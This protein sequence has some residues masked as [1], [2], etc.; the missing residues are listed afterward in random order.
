[1][2]CRWSLE[3]GGNF[4][5]SSNETPPLLFR[6]ICLHL[7]R[8]LGAGEEQS[9]KPKT[10][11]FPPGAKKPDTAGADAPPAAAAAAAVEPADAGVA[12]PRL[13]D[14]PS[15]IAATFF[16]LLQK[17]EL[18]PAYDSLTRGSKIA[19]RPEELKTLKNKTREA[20]E[21]FGA[22]LGYELVESKPIGSRLLRRTYISLG[23]EFPLRWRLYFYKSENVWRLI[24]LRVDDRLTGM[25]D[26]QEEPRAPEAKP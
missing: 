9:E 21:V 16:G 11:I 15:Q 20:I 6:G 24:D 25:F 4:K 26:E 1:M 12:T 13:Q 5:R 18:D 22:V 23:K 7:F 14:P 3:L 8:C 10:L 2:V 17:G 19:E